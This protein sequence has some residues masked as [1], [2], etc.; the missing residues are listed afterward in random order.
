MLQSKFSLAAV[1]VTLSFSGVASA[2]PIGAEGLFFSAFNGDS[3][4]PSSIVINLLETTSEFRANPNAPRALEGES[5]AVLTAW[6]GEQSDLGTLRWSVLGASIGDAFS[7]PPS[8][9][10]GGLSTSSNLDTLPEQ[11]SG[12][13]NG[14][15][16]VVL[17]FADFRNNKVNANLQGDVNAFYAANQTQYFFASQDGG[18][19]FESRGAL[20]ESLPFYAFFAD[21]SGNEFFEGDFTKFDGSW[22][23]N[24]DDGVASLTYSA[25][26]V[27]V[28]AAVWLFGSALAGIAGVARRRI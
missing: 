27:P 11:G 25:A 3:S 21:Q 7:S 14:L 24:F 28:P 22:T 6:L 5:L 1:A 13:F 4:A 10:H 17:N 9:L 18:A 12:S 19:N 2:A 26:P 16:Q 15:D 20:G 8:P 23:L